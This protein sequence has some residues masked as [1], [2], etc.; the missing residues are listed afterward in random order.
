MPLI[1]LSCCILSCKASSSPDTLGH[2][3]AGRA[4]LQAITTSDGEGSGGSWNQSP[5]QA[6]HANPLLY[7]QGRQRC[8]LG[9]RTYAASHCCFYP[10]TE[11]GAHPDASPFA[12][13]S[14]TWQDQKSQ[15]CGD[16][17]CTVCQD[18]LPI[19]QPP[20]AISGQFLKPQVPGNSLQPYK[21]HQACW[22]QQHCQLLKEK[23][24]S[25]EDAWASKFTRVRKSG[26]LIWAS[27]KGDAKQPPCSIPITFCLTGAAFHA[28]ALRGNLIHFLIKHQLPQCNAP[29]AKGTAP[30]YTLKPSLGGSFRF[31]KEG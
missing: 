26:A 7:T 22:R 8:L 18:S 23:L 5:A 13:L 30:C 4:L 21:Q 3:L 15:D 29:N 17:S 11:S 10:E 9:M 14:A 24:N 6:S 2:G 25:S 16:P 31:Y 20:I 27:Y 12:A 19:S 28:A 1:S